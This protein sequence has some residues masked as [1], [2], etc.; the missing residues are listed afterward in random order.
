M[1]TTKTRRKVDWLEVRV[2][3]EEARR[4]KEDERLLSQVQG[5][6]FDVRRLNDHVAVLMKHLGLAFNQDLRVVKVEG[7]R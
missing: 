5:I 7:K 4:L 2:A 1:M 6:D 3:T